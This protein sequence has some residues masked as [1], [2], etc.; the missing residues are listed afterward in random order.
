VEGVV[1][2][3]TTEGRR[4][5]IH[6]E[7]IAA[8]ALEAL[9][10]QKYEGQALPITGPAAVTFGEVAERISAAIGKTLTFLPI[11]DE[12]ARRRYSVISGSDEETEA[13]VALW[14][15]IREGRLATVNDNVEHILGRNPI[16]LDQWIKEN[17]A[18]FQN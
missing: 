10:T 15:A 16:G 11:S 6:S 13:H 12:E 1:R 3:S 8:V 14:R 2:S 18:A 7:D 4:A 9:T 17:I 5:F